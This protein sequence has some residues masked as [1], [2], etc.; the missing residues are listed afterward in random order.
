[1]RKKIHPFLFFLYYVVK[2][3]LEKKNIFIFFFN[4]FSDHFSLK[5]VLFNPKIY[6]VHISVP[7]FDRKERKSSKNKSEITLTKKIKFGVK[8]FLLK[9]VVSFKCFLPF[10]LS[11][12]LD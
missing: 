6:F 3:F 7:E 10:I 1:V 9:I 11:E 8:I 4:F 5:I 2:A 12:K